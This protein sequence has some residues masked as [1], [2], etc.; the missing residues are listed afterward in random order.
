M[1]SRRTASCLFALAIT[2]AISCS[3]TT[4][5]AGPVSDRQLTLE[6]CEI[7]GVTQAAQCGTLE[8]PERR[9]GRSQQQQSRHL[10]SDDGHIARGRKP[11]AH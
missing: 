11:I 1:K 7:P 6:P 3:R 10:Y 8:D 4:L 5:Q 2:G 9:E